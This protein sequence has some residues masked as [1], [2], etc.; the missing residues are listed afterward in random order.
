[1]A[2][3]DRIERRLALSGDD[4]MLRKRKVAAFFAGLFGSIIALVFVALYFSVGEPLPA[5]LYISTFVWTTVGL[6]VLWRRPHAYYNTVL[7]TTVY[8]TIHPWVVTLYTGGY[9]SGLLPMLWALLGPGFAVLL[10]GIRPALFDSALYVLMACVVALLDPWAA[11][12]ALDLPDW[13]RLLA[14]TLSA[15]TPGMMVV[16]VSLFLFRQAERARMQADALLRNILP[17]PVADRLKIDPTTIAD[18]FGAVTVLFADLVGF[19]QMSAAANPQEVVGLLNAVFSE[20]DALTEKHG[21]EKIKTIGDAYM[22]VGGLPTPR[23]DHVEAVAA[24]AIDALEVLKHHRAL[25]GNPLSIRIGINTGPT[26]AG[27]IGRR[28]FIYDLWGDTVNTASRM[29]S[30]GLENAIQVTQAVRD[31]L[32]ERYVFEER[33]PIE[34][35]GK[36]QM[37]TYLLRPEIRSAQPELPR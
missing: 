35:K 2:L 29:E 37:M 10:I 22:V 28:K 7:L 27:V 12:H 13:F 36:G 21:L 4:D 34:V 17:S 8:V 3:I 9:S 15:V 1:M 14:G 5:W 20:F 32:H 26:V 18:S 23:P 6:A 33:G 19:T 30:F 25:D 31:E 24:F 16:F 11:T